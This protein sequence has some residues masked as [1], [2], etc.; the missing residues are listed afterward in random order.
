VLPIHSAST[1]AG[2]KTTG[3]D[4]IHRSRWVE[5]VSFALTAVA[6]V[7]ILTSMIPPTHR[8]RIL[9]RPMVIGHQGTNRHAPPNT[10]KAFKRAARHADIIETDIQF[11]QDGYMVVF[12]D[13]VLDDATNCTGTVADKTYVQVRRCNT[14][15]GAPL[16]AFR[17][18]LAWIATTQLTLVAEMKFEGWTSTQVRAYGRSVRRWGMASRTIASSFFVDNL[19]Q[20]RA[21]NPEIKTALIFSR[22]VPPLDSIRAAGATS[23]PWI[24]NITERQVAQQHA[25]GIQVWGWTARSASQYQ[26]AI[27]LGV[28][29][30]V[31][32]D[33][34][35]AQKWLDAN[36][37]RNNPTAVRKR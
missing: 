36:L 34:K 33:P 20:M 28:D 6:L 4:G 2:T 18:L 21:A 1:P 26:L 5:V 9:R 19:V 23:M 30:I 13:K 25:A 32:D 17:E 31:V 24:K 8:A 16:P 14:A 37:P 3:G 7:S 27:D 12:H 11:T 22:D 10:M 35:T 29:G 15:D